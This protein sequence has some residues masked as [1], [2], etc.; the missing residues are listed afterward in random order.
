MQL[1]SSVSTVLGPLG[2][3]QVSAPGRRGGTPRAADTS[4]GWDCSV[5]ESK[6]RPISPWLAAGSE[7]SP[8]N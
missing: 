5:G 3:L 8:G 1:T 6:T 4:Q 2:I 7:G